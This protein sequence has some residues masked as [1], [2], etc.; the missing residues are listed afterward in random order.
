MITLQAGRSHAEA[1]L[2]D[3]ASST[4]IVDVRPGVIG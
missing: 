1:C 2:G 4:E 3:T